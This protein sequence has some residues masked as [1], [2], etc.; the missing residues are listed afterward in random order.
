VLHATISARFVTGFPTHISTCT[1]ANE[2]G[3]GVHYLNSK[4]E[5]GGEKKA[6]N[7]RLRGV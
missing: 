6:R 5:I 1:I 7:N 3:E 2:L 4:L